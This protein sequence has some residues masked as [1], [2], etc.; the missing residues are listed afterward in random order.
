MIERIKNTSIVI[1]C[2]LLMCFGCK[3]KHIEIIIENS[4]DIS[5]S[6]SI[7]VMLDS[8]VLY[9]NI[10]V[11]KDKEKLKFESV[12]IDFPENKTDVRLNFRM[13][14]TGELT[15]S[16]VIKDSI[17][18]KAI[19]HVNFLEVRFL[20]GFELGTR[21]LDKDSIVRREFYSEIIYK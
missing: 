12:N 3:T 8:A 16:T 1:S 11:K 14:N 6:I 17:K 10:S 4:S 2:L 18:Q 7:D 9:K 15:G 13:N 20:K 5:D 21:V 19:I